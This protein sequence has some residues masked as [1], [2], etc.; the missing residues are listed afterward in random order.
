ME[1]EAWELV[2]GEHPGPPQRRGRLISAEYGEMAQSYEA[3]PPRCDEMVGEPY[4][5]PRE[6]PPGR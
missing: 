4:L 6:D 5:A 2:E 1:S 3:D